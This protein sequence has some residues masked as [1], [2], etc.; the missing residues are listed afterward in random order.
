MKKLLIDV[1]STSVKW[2]VNSE[3]SGKGE[4]GRL[5]FPSPLRH[6]PPFFEVNPEAIWNVVSAIVGQ[7]GSV[8]CIALSVQMHG[9]V[10]GDETGRAVSP[11]VSW[12]DERATLPVGKSTYLEQFPARIE[13]QSG[14][15]LKANLP[16]VS[17]YAMR[18]IEP[19]T[20]RR[21]RMFF[22]L[23]SY[24]AFRLTGRNATHLT[25]AAPS[26]F[27]DVT[28]CR[29]SAVAPAWLSLPEAVESLRPIGRDQGVAVHPPVG[30]QQASV[31][32]A[33]LASDAFLLNLGTAAQLCAV[34]PSPCFGEFE[35]RPYFNGATLCTVTRLLGGRDI[36]QHE[37]DP[38]FGDRMTQDYLQ[39]IRKLPPR[40][41]LRVI[42]GAAQHYRSLI[43]SVCQRLALPYTVEMES[44]ALDGL[45]KLVAMEKSHETH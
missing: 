44:D 16:A 30:D 28:T 26:G 5:P 7:A 31:M 21:S 3:K 12:Q 38:A 25:D 40:R 10:L 8:D 4:V 11:Y 33:G 17:L 39:A 35:S 20:L 36:R 19:E 34:E 37:N 2:T 32:G 1:G 24:L 6:E 29:P 27:Y 42:G 43:D 23:G 41:R 13:R 15:S 14:T 22:T 9:Y 18:T 45:N